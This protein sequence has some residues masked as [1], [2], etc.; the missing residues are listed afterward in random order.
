MLSIG[1]LSILNQRLKKRFSR[2]HW[3]VPLDRRKSK[4]SRQS[5]LIRNTSLFNAP[6]DD[7]QIWM[8][9]DASHFLSPGTMHRRP[10]SHPPLQGSSVPQALQQEAEN[11]EGRA[12]GVGVGA[13]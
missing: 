13:G 8:F 9:I 2:N 7:V 4:S 3:Y 6:Q 10:D 12:V 5:P 1:V 11:P